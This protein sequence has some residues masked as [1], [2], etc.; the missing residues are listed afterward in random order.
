MINV[1]RVRQLSGLTEKMSKS[2]LNGVIVVTDSI[3]APVAKSKNGKA[4]LGSFPVN[5]VVASLD[6]VSKH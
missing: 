6:V 2:L 5:A 1:L 4:I 3:S